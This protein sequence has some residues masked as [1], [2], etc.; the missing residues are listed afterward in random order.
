M[1]KCFRAS[2]LM[3]VMLAPRWAVAD[4][5]FGRLV[6]FGDSLSD[7]GNA[8]VLIGQVSVAPFAL[9]PD[10]PYARGGLHF[11]NGETWV[12]Q[13]AKSLQL[14][15]SA[16]PALRAPGVFSNY[17]VGGAR[18]RPGGQVDL[19]TEVGLFLVDVGNRAPGDALYV[20]FIGGNDVRD[21]LG[22]LAMDPSGGASGT[23]L[24]QAVTAIAD[25]ITLLASIGARRFLVVNAPDLGLVPAVRLQGPAVQASARWLSMAFNQRLEGV[26]AG[27]EA[28]LPV[29]ITHFDLFSFID[30]TVASPASAGFTEVQMPCVTPGTTVHAICSHPDAYLFWDGIHPTR[31]GH[32]V[33]ARQVG[34]ILAQP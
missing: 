14:N 3:L 12:E 32:A 22:A 7:S 20:V 11:S 25:N 33:L 13:L 4:G 28:A 9:I 21:A 19:T 18:A 29:T 2:V 30:N 27:V 24:V 10:A 5:P 8:F 31:R 16:G 15:A 6:T 26:L 1:R 34:A 17:A 23:I